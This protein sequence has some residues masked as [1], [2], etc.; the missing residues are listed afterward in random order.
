MFGPQPGDIVR[1]LD[2]TSPASIQQ[3]APDWPQHSSAVHVEALDHHWS[4]YVV[5]RDL[6]PIVPAGTHLIGTAETPHG[7]LARPD[8][9]LCHS[10]A[11]LNSWCHEACKTLDRRAQLTVLD[12]QSETALRVR[13]SKGSRAGARHRRWPSSF[14]TAPTSPCSSRPQRNCFAGK[15]APCSEGAKGLPSLR[16]VSRAALRPSELGEAWPRRR[17]RSALIGSLVR[18]LEQ[19]ASGNRRGVNLDQASHLGREAWLE[20][21]RPVAS[22]RTTRSPPL[23]RRRGVLGEHRDEFLERHQLQ[24]FSPMLAR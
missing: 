10:E 2:V 19:T 13:N 22:G 17:R 5:Q 4:G 12:S 20:T 1:V 3:A 6:E 21:S 9:A 15:P 16:S 7:E 24:I 8:S 18:R 23:E 14:Q 11:E